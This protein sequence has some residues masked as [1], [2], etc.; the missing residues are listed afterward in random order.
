MKATAQPSAI[1]PSIVLLGLAALAVISIGL[2]GTALPVLSNLRVDI[3]L[4]FVLGK[5]ICAQGGTGRVSA[6][7][8]W[9]HPLAILG[10]LLGVVIIIV[11]IAALFGLQLPLIRDDRQALIAIAVLAGVQVLNAN[12]HSL[13]ARR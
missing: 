9:T 3:I 4:L 6:T 12:L 7:H 11:T 2:A 1:T 5:L 8:Q 10:S 13:L